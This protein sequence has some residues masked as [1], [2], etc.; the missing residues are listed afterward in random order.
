MLT[1]NGKT[2]DMM[3]GHLGQ[4]VIVQPEDNIIIIRLG[5]Q[6]SPDGTQPFYR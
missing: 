4:Y 6:K 5:H 3:R 1:L 2:F